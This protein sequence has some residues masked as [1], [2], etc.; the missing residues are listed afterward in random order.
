M[1]LG[2]MPDV[3]TTKRVRQ[4]GL[5]IA[6]QDV[7]RGLTKIAQLNEQL[8]T[9]SKRA[10]HFEEQIAV[11]QRQHDE[12]VA[13]R[14]QAHLREVGSLK[15]QFEQVEQNSNRMMN[16]CNEVGTELQGLHMLLD[17]LPHCPART[18]KTDDGDVNLS[19]SIR[20]AGWQA[21]LANNLAYNR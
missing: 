21:M 7:Q 19:L 14:A 20:F 6:L 5:Q 3:G 8:E 2:S 11:Q 13:E 10:Q 12:Y 17:M 16:L 1:E 18:K 9:V 4:T 15:G